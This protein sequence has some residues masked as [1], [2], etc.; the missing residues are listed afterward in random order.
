MKTRLLAS[1]A[2][3]A[4]ASIL[5]VSTPVHAQSFTW[6][7][8]YAGVNAGG[9]WGRSE[10]STTTD[11]SVPF[12]P[13]YFCFAGSGAANGLAVAASGTGSIKGS[14]FTGGVQAG[15]NWQSNNL[16][17][18]LEADFGAFNLSGS[19]R[20]SA[21]YPVAAGGGGPTTANV[22]TVGSSFDTDWL[23]T[24][25]GRLGWTLSPNLLVYATGGW[26]VTDLKVSNS[27]SDDYI[28]GGATQGAVE[29]ASKSTFKSGAV[30]GG[31]LEWALGNR[32]TVK[33]EYLYLNFGKVIASGVISNAGQGAG[34]AQALSTSSDMT[35][36]VARLGVNYKF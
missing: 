9:A 15:Y 19:R 36:H 3:T 23:F 4:L 21:N 22:Y 5:G 34:Y 6:A 20:A 16:V 14:G 32:W 1:A 31:G 33:G 18:G 28:G 27:F 7:G 13:G 10:A 11:C 30:V 29:N 12:T 25:R 17:Y 24:F 2:G 35:A 8:F 26:A